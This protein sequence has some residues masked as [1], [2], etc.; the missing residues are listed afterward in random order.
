MQNIWGIV[1]GIVVA[2]GIG[3]AVYKFVDTGDSRPRATVPAPLAT[4]APAGA[5]TAQTAP[6]PQSDAHFD[7]MQVTVADFQLGKPDAPITIVEYASLTCP[8]CAAF[9]AEVM[10]RL[11]SEY[12]EA[13]KVRFV[14]RDFPLDRVALTAS[15]VARCAGRDRFFGYIEAFFSNQQTWT[16]AQNPVEAL[17]R[18]ARLGGMGDAEFD[19]CLKDQTA[20]DAVLAQRLDGENTFKIQSTPT[21]FVNG[22][23]YTGGLRYEDLK[24]VLDGKMPKS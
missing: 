11:K 16:R 12:I 15:V 21:I 1:V 14:Y 20:L 7:Q 4:G 22:D 8:H 5:A 13:G 9:D 23:R 6:L 24:R 17:G 18:I 19:A 2:A 3:A 10:P